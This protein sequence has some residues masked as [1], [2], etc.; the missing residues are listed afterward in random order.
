MLFTP[1]S[2]LL[3]FNILLGCPKLFDPFLRK[4]FSIDSFLVICKIL[5]FGNLSRKM[6]SMN[7]RWY[8]I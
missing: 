1:D 6:T 4:I 5:S 2:L 7:M 8:F 3:V